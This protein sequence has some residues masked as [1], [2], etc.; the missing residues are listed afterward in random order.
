MI[1]MCNGEITSEQMDAKWKEI[2]ENNKVIR[3]DWV[4]TFVKDNFGAQKV[5]KDSATQT[6]YAEVVKQRD[7]ST[8]FQQAST[9]KIKIHHEKNSKNFVQKKKTRNYYNVD[10]EKK[11]S[12]SEDPEQWCKKNLPKM[13][14][15]NKSSESSKNSQY[16]KK[17]HNYN[18]W[19]NSSKHEKVQN[20]NE[21]NM[22]F[23]RN[24][25]DHSFNRKRYSPSLQR[26]KWQDT[27][28]ARN[29]ICA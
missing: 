21:G 2:D 24:S 9:E 18:S 28:N 11:P 4:N 27:Q 5:F 22:I 17:F 3:K 16:N 1:K 26:R 19:Q 15:I 8:D 10:E 20:T 29:Y 23:K 6:T 14:S 13:Q 25:H 12:T 7:K